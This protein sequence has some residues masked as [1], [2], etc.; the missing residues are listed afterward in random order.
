MRTA[1]DLER[2]QLM[3]KYRIFTNDRGRVAGIPKY[4]ALR[5]VRAKTADQAVL[6]VNQAFGQHPLAPIK[7]IEWPPDERGREWLEKH[8]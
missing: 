2:V 7:A 5:E 8:V 4:S 6:L 3:T 1:P